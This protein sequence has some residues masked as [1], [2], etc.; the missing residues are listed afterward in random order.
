LCN[1]AKR[2][3]ELVRNALVAAKQFHAPRVVD[4]LKRTINEFSHPS[5]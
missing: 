1:D 2:R 3:E 5:T 4:A